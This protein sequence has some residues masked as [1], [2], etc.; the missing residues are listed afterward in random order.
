[1]TED[2]KH[3]ADAQEFLTKIRTIMIEA[4]K[5]SPE[6]S[7]DVFRKVERLTDDLRRLLSE[8]TYR[9]NREFAAKIRSQFSDHF[10]EWLSKL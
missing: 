5:L 9:A 2:K 10:A 1:M 8:N 6:T 4:M 7:P 3:E